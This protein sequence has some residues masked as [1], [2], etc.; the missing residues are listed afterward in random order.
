MVINLLV[1]NLVVYSLV[2]KSVNQPSISKVFDS[3]NK[4]VI[5]YINGLGRREM[6]SNIQVKVVVM[7]LQEEKG[8]IM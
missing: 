8:C 5:D 7:V 6:H 1:F 4:S 2:L 3:V